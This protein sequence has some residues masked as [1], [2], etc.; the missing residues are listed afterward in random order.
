[1]VKKCAY[2]L[3]GSPA[4][5]KSTITALLLKRLQ[6]RVATL[7]LDSFRW[8]YHLK[9][10]E[11]S[12]I[13][14]DEHLLAFSNFLSVLENYCANGTYTLLLEGLF[15]WAKASPHG[16]MKDILECLRRYGFHLVL[17]RLEAP[18]E[19]L[20]QRNLKRNYV[21]PRLEFEELFANVMEDSGIEERKIDVSNLSEED[22]LEQILAY[23]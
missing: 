19:V 1:M 4:S 14:D 7:E 8:S 15:A 9:P 6:G 22:T 18:L 3:R 13:T 16:N 11:I 5:G 21:V 20:W 23:T 10:R 17:V 2:V 12:E